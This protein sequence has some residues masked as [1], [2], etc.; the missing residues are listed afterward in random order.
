M[1]CAAIYIRVSTEEQTEYSPSAQKK[2][3]LEYAEKNKYYISP[4]L[5]FVDEGFSGKTAEKR[6]AFMKMISIAKSK[7]KKFDTILIHKFD[8]FARNREDSVV[9][10]SMLRKECGVKVI[11]IT[12][13]LENDDKMSVITEA[14]LEAMAEFYSINLAEEVKKGMTEKAKK[15][16]FQTSPPLGYGIKNNNL[17][18]IEDEASCIKFIFNQFVIYNKSPYQISKELNEINQLSKRGNKIDLRNVE[19]ILQNP[20]YIGMVR[21]TPSGKAKRDFNHPD[22]IIE[23]GKHEAIISD[24]L[25]YKAKEKFEISRNKNKINA[26]P[27]SDCKH[28][29]SGLI[30]CSNCGSSLTLANSLKY[31]SF[32]CSSYCKGKCRVSHSISLKKIENVMINELSHVFEK[33]KQVKYYRKDLSFDEKSEQIELCK[34]QSA[35]IEIKLSKLNDG[36]LSGLFS[37]K[38][39]LEQKKLLEFQNKEIKEK[40]LKLQNE[41]ISAEQDDSKK[42]FY[43]LVEL[44]NANTEIETKIKALRSIIEKII[45]DKQK[46]SLEIYF[47]DS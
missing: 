44:V 16:G 33:I 7:D 27:I 38:D 6:P 13:S 41:K 47:C 43:N 35:K 20:I 12:E 23:K 15:G 3:I 5:I 25:F 22:S 2:A 31:P 45:Y 17:I 46:Y 28:C 11:S 32:Q 9:Y 14:F 10:K 29:L 40:I 30:K 26:R 19:Y 21:W 24:E 8:R 42:Y 39:F 1:H 18:V 34:K 4:E 37:E 36:Y